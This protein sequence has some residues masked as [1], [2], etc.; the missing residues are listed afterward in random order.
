MCKRCLMDKMVPE[1]YRWERGNVK[2]E[3]ADGEYHFED[4]VR[5]EEIKSSHDGFV[6]IGSG[7]LTQDENGFLLKGTLFNGEDFEL[8]RSV[9]SMYSCHIEYNYKGRGDA[10]ELCTL[11]DTYFVYPKTFNNVLTKLHFAT[12]ELY[13]KLY[14]KSEK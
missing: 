3:V 5:I 4:E 2:Q 9:A 8:H 14:G 11:S 7:K 10:L 6:E 13:D 1:W 12:E